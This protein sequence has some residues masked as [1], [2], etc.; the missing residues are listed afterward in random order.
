MLILLL[1]S[2]VQGEFLLSLVPADTSSTITWEN[3]A[4]SN[5]FQKTGNDFDM[6]SSLLTDQAAWRW[7]RNWTTVWVS[8]D[9]C[10]CN[11]KPLLLVTMQ[12]DLSGAI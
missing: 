10:P 3:S 8:P 9:L 1:S 11:S 6:S 4:D 7:R 12:A 5:R 2:K